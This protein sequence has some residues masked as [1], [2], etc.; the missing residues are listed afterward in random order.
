MVSR[1]CTSKYWNHKYVIHTTKMETP[2]CYFC[3]ITNPIC[4]SSCTSF[5]PPEEFEFDT[6]FYES[7][8]SPWLSLKTG[9]HDIPLPGN[10]KR[11][12]CLK[13]NNSLTA[14]PRATYSASDVERV[15][16]YCVLENQH[17]YAPAHIIAPP[18]TD[19]LSVALLA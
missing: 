6:G 4:D 3:Y 12:T 14:S 13:N 19:R 1:D 18:D 7:Y 17:T 15:A 5:S 16:H 8:T 9:K 11:H 10:M 2:Y